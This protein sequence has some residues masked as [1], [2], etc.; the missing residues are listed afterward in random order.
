MKKLSIY[1]C[2]GVVL[3][4]A[5][6][7]FMSAKSEFLSCEDVTELG[8]KKEVQEYAISWV[9]DFWNDGRIDESL[10][11]HTVGVSPGRSRIKVPVDWTKIGFRSRFSRANLINPLS[12]D[13]SDQ[14][15][16]LERFDRSEA[17]FFA[18]SSGLGFYVTINDG[19]L[20]GVLSSDFLTKLNSRFYVLCIPRRR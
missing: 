12:E 20:S 15:K 13:P 1:T 14:T 10:L 3:V 6:T 11:R 16:T 4:F 18:Y 5:A 17:V 8:S 2:L 7:S 19:P 9:D